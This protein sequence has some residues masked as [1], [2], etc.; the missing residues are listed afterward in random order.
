VRDGGHTVTDPGCDLE[1]DLKLQKF[2]GVPVRKTL[3]AV[4]TVS[5]CEDGVIFREGTVTGTGNVGQTFGRLLAS[6]S[7]K[8]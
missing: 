7:V 8:E 3:E 6:T 4:P 1:S 5:G 2:E